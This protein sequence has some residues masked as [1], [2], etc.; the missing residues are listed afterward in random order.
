MANLGVRAAV[1]E[2]VKTRLDEAGTRVEE[3]AVTTD[4]LTPF[5][6]KV[7]LDTG[8]EKRLLSVPA[9]V[10]RTLPQG[11]AYAKPE[12]GLLARLGERSSLVAT[13]A[14]FAEFPVVSADIRGST[15]REMTFMDLRFQTVNPVGR[16]IVDDYRPPFTLGVVLGPD[17]ALREV[18]YERHGEVMVQSVP[19]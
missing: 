17:G 13:W 16:M 6:W 19:D 15:G 11:L 9:L 8:T 10:P 14:W 3:V 5:Y 4:L 12:P 18:R 7:V 1:A 2:A